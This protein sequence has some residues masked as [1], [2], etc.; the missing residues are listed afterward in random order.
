MPLIPDG[1]SPR[2]N[3]TF[4]PAPLVRLAPL[5]AALLLAALSLALVPS[6][7]R[8]ADLAWAQ[9]TGEC[10][11][12]PGEGCG[13]LELRNITTGDQ[14]QITPE[15]SFG[16][17]GNYS[18]PDAALSP[19]GQ[20]VAYAGQRD[21]GFILP[22]CAYSNIHMLDLASGTDQTVYQGVEDHPDWRPDG[23]SLVLMHRGNCFAETLLHI[24]T[25]EYGSTP[26]TILSGA[27]DPAYSPDGSRIAYANLNDP[28]K[29]LWLANPDGS[30]PH[31][32]MTS[33]IRGVDTALEPTFSPNGL[34]LGFVAYQST[35]KGNKYSLWIIN[36][37]GTGAKQ[38][39]AWTSSRIGPP[40]WSPDG[41]GIVYDI[42]TGANMPSAGYYWYQRDLRIVNPDG[43]NDHVVVPNAGLAP[44]NPAFRQNSS[45]A[46]EDFDAVKFEPKLFFDKGEKWR[47]LNV[48]SFFQEVN[49]A[50]NLSLNRVCD[51]I[52]PLESCDPLTLGDDA[53]R[54]HPWSTS[55]VVVGD[56]AP[57][58]VTPSPD[59]YHSPDPSCVDSAAANA[60]VTVLDCNSGSASAIYYQPTFRSSGYSY[61]DYWFFYRYNGFVD[62]NHQADWEG[63]TIGLTSPNAQTFDWASFA[64]HTYNSDTDTGGPYIS[65]DQSAQTYLRTSLTCDGGGDGSCGALYNGYKGN[66]LW[67]YAAGG[68]HAS[69][70]DKCSNFCTQPGIATLE[71]DHGGQ[72]EWGNDYT[73]MIG[74]KRFPQDRT[75]D[76]LSYP[77]TQAVWTDWPGKWGLERKPDSPGNQK[78]FKCPWTNNPSDAT[79][80]TARLAAAR[81]A[82]LQVIARCDSWYG[83]SV[84]AAACS[85]RR[86][87][88]AMRHARVGHRGSMRIIVRGQQAATGS[89][90][91]IAQS[92]G[93]P[94]RPGSTVL[95]RGSGPADTELAV[96]AR[97]GRRLIQARFTHLGLRR[98]GRATVRMSRRGDLLLRTASGVVRRP[99]TLRIIRLKA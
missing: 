94:L 36:T 28:G 98:G 54:L 64:E 72:V 76:W 32:I 92:V 86:L 50:T 79:A 8:A 2:V 15:M 61:I 47:P 31:E 85:P 71:G 30:S 21:P 20:V 63:V 83:G 65:S 25:W 41:A 19:D 56:Q 51:L 1:P 97:V 70:P 81:A 7:A 39:V 42:Q 80:C 60:T 68:T 33:K 44:A 96:N 57:A 27:Q 43:S 45:L 74:L 34:Q 10:A 91:G 26:V 5:F 40:D 69:Y 14:S 73:S 46:P 3:S 66:R 17:Y 55:T 59:D 23:K 78:R 37:D 89:G 18:G 13:H 52:D 9:G 48:S 88:W 95:L 62:D 77:Y 24:G 58:G 75:G 22:N 11:L 82:K 84:V 12:A 87:G 35:S 4:A 29:D 67:V 93:T 49:P 99:A 16:N 53:L 38:L 90:Q 6:H